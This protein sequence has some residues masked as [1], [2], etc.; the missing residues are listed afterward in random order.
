MVESLPPTPAISQM[1][2]GCFWVRD[3]VL[4]S[5]EEGRAFRAGEVSRERAGEMT[6]AIKAARSELIGIEVEYVRWFHPWRRN[7][8]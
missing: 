7:L 2:P 1:E 5:A 8:V 4:F 3:G 6:L